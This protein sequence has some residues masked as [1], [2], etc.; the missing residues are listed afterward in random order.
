MRKHEAFLEAF[1]HLVN[2]RSTVL[3]GGGAWRGAEGAHT[4][5]GIHSNVA[6]SQGPPEPSPLLLGTHSR[7][8]PGFPS[9]A[10]S[11]P[12]WLRALET[13]RL[14]GYLTGVGCGGQAIKGQ[15]GEEG[16]G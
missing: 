8:R 15:G 13:S 11:R 7:G 2:P 1:S 5:N 4:Q 3:L 12:L 14:N 16:A 10:K 6:I 9:K